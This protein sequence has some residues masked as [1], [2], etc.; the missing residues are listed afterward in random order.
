MHKNHNIEGKTNAENLMTLFN[1]EINIGINSTV[2]ESQFQM[3]RRKRVK[4]PL[5]NIKK[6]HEYLLIERRKAFNE[7]SQN[8]TLKSWKTLC[9]TT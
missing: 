5:N 2:A 4:L 6:L 1:E 9:E 8:F 7:L 3:Q